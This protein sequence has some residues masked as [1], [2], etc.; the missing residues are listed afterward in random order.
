MQS[1]KVQPCQVP[2]LSL[3]CVPMPLLH[4]LHCFPMPLLL[5][6]LDF[7]LLLPNQMQPCKAP[8]PSS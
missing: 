8:H 5:I 2:M 1:S 3:Q 7:P 6:M 4:F